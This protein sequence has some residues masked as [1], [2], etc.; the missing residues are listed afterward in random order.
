MKEKL[1]EQ[2]SAMIDDELETN[3]QALLVRQL[4]GDEPLRVRLARYQVISDTLRDHLPER[5]DP[6]FHMRVQAALQ[7]EPEPQA[8]PVGS[9]FGALLKPLAGLAVAASVAIVAVLSLQS[10]RDPGTPSTPAIASAPA[11][12]DYIRAEGQSPSVSPVS[13]VRDLDAYLV[14]HNEFAVNRGMQGMLPYVRIVGQG[15]QSGSQEDTE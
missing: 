12:A 2:L 10:V 5:L 15:E 13:P 4:V 3:E 11:P 14:N 9:R 8:I 1:Y 6:D 7:D